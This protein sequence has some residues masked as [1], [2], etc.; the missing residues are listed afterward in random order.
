[1]R[2]CFGLITILFFQVSFVFAESSSSQLAFSA[3]TFTSTTGQQVPYRILLPEN[4]DPKKSYPMMVWL[5]G[6]GESGNNNTSQ[7]NNGIEKFLEPEVHQ[8]FPGIIVAPQCPANDE[9]T[10]MGSKYRTGEQHM[11]QQP[12]AIA[13]ASFQLIEHLQKKYKVRTQSTSLVGLSMGGFAVTDWMARRPDLFKKGIAMSGGG[14]QSK[15]KI[16]A[17]S[18]LWFFHGDKDPVIELSQSQEMVNVIRKNGGQP[19]L[20]VLSGRGHGPWKDLVIKPEVLSWLLN[21]N[22]PAESTPTVH[23]ATL[24]EN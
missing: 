24:I 8:K 13:K 5:H 20:T 23:E 15:A 12:T 19:R 16:L 3:E 22:K 21:S 2:Y 7:I 14:D 10:T 18:Q 1:M 11:T 6:R 9:W 17:Q 4:Y